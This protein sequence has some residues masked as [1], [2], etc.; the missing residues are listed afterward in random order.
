MSRVQILSHISCVT[1]GHL[2]S[3]CLSS[4]ITGSVVMGIKMLIYVK[5]EELCQH[6]VSY[7][8]RGDNDDFHVSF[9]LY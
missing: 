9:P 3:L 7:N 8:K 4:L 1:L 5:H 6:T 2:A